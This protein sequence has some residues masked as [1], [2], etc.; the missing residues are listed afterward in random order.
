MAARIGKSKNFSEALYPGFQLR[1]GS[2]VCLKSLCLTL[3]KVIN[4]FDFHQNSRQ[5]LEEVN[6]LSGA[7]HTIDPKGPKFHQNSV[8]EMAFRDNQHFQF[9]SKLKM[10]DRI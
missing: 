6:I 5:H 3:F 2:K 1:K 7:L 8:L 9:Q 4:I 10:A